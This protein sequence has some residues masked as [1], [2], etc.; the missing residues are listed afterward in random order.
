MLDEY[1]MLEHY[2]FGLKPEISVYYEL[3]SN[4]INTLGHSENFVTF[5]ILNTCVFR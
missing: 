3:K 4:E 2:L 5:K 1:R